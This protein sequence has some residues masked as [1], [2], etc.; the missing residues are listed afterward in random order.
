MVEASDIMQSL[1]ITTIWNVTKCSHFFILTFFSVTL[2]FRFGNITR[3]RRRQS[4]FKCVVLHP[5]YGYVLYIVL[6]TF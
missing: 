6:L 1:L 5:S 4:I 2:F 3:I